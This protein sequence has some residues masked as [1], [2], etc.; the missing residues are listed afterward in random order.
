MIKVESQQSPGAERSQLDVFG[1]IAAFA[2]AAHCLCLPVL[3]ALAPW[4]GIELLDNHLFDIGLVLFALTI[5]GYAIARGVRRHRRSQVLAWFSIAVVLLLTGLATVHDGW[6]HAPILAV[7]GAAL[8]WAH[9]LNL[10]FD[11]ARV[12]GA[13]SWQQDPVSAAR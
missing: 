1:A 2:C 13:A 12:L 7:G 4:T 9:L 6:M 8:G 11:R 5:G 3:L 10:R